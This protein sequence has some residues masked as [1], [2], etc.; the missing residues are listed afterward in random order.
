MRIRILI[1]SIALGA[2]CTS[3]QMAA[4][5]A[6]VAGAAKPRPAL[7]VRFDD[8]HPG[9]ISGYIVD[10][11][12]HMALPSRA[13]VIAQDTLATGRPWAAETDSSGWFSLEVRPGRFVFRTFGITYDARIDTVV[14]PEG[15]GLSVVIPLTQSFRLET[16][17]I[18]DPETRLRVKI[19]VPPSAPRTDTATISIRIR[20]MPTEVVRQPVAMFS[21][22]WPVVSTTRKPS[23]TTADVEVRVPGFRT[24]RDRT[25][26]LAGTVTVVLTPNR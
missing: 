14:M 25:V 19:V 20:D 8:A 6:F 13:M 1:L 3:G 15:R 11:S 17:I 22:G 18:N 10:D 7:E 4:K 2:A 21:D 9:I 26:P 5:G 16:V 12:L 23:A 24:W